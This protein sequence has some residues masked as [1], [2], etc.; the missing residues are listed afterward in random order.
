MSIEYSSKKNRGLS[1]H[2]QNKKDEEKIK[3]YLNSMW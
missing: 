2:K 3:E 1:P